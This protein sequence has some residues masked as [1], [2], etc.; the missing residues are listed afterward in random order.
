MLYPVLTSYLGLWDEQ[1]SPPGGRG[2]CKGEEGGK[3]GLTTFLEGSLR[4]KSQRVNSKIKY[5]F[6][7]FLPG[8]YLS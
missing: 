4:D 5:I 2:S 6:I 1:L 7:L 8:P 3:G